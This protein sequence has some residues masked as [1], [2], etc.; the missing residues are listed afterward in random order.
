[1]QTSYS[2]NK[3]KQ[4]E[5][6]AGVYEVGEV[7]PVDEEDVK[8]A[9]G[10]VGHW[11]FEVYGNGDDGEGCDFV[12]VA[13]DLADPF[14]DAVVDHQLVIGKVANN[15]RDWNDFYYRIAC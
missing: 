5:G 3:E 1:M 15:A 13:E 10:D 4:S 8:K 9:N 11:L 6:P 14:C 12:D 2:V 7:V